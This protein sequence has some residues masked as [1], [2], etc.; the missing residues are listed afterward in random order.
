MDFNCKDGLDSEDN[1][2]RNDGLVCNAGLEHRRPGICTVASVYRIEARLKSLA[3]S[4]IL[5]CN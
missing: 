3:R 5:Q 2:N 4:L 1:S